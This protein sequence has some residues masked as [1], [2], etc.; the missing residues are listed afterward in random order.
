MPVL[1]QYTAL[2]VRTAWLPKVHDMPRCGSTCKIISI[3]RAL[4]G[5]DS[6]P[7][8][9]KV[10]LVHRTSPRKKWHCRSH[11]CGLDQVTTVEQGR[12]V[13]KVRTDPC[14]AAETSAPPWRPHRTLAFPVGEEPPVAQFVSTNT[15]RMLAIVLCHRCIRATCLFTSANT[16]IAI[17]KT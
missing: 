4:T 7:S 6:A 15:G 17:D 11:F 16:S 1:K 14:A 13:R 8:V 5:S 2:T 3:A 10:M 9:A 12:W